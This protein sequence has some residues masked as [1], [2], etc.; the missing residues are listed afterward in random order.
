LVLP[1]R[2]ARVERTCGHDVV[3]LMNCMHCRVE[4]DGTAMVNCRSD[5]QVGL[6]KN[7]MVTGV[8]HLAAA[9]PLRREG[10]QLRAGFRWVH[11][12]G[13]RGG[14]GNDLRRLLNDNRLVITGNHGGAMA[15]ERDID[16]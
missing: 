9:R 15:A 5:R 16:L 6:D 10:L 1:D 4:S 8:E 13:E 2:P 14:L 3:G 11:P 7:Q 12:R